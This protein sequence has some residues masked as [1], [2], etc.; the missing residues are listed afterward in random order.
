MG[1]NVERI[2]SERISFPERTI[3]VFLR[4][5]SNRRLCDWLANHLDALVVGEDFWLF[6]YALYSTAQAR[7]GQQK[8]HP[9][10]GQF[11]VMKLVGPVG[12]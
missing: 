7:T 9:K 5:H 12:F 8:D 3:V 10:G 6:H 1:E 4:L 2:V 11:A